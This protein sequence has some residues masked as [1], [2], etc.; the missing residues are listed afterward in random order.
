M[1]HTSLEKSQAFRRK[2]T[3]ALLF[4][5]RHIGLVVGPAPILPVQDQALMQ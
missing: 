2:D 3:P 5:P 1:S 4:G